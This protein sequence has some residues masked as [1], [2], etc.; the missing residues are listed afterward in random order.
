MD[1][2]HNTK[3]HN[4]ARCSIASLQSTFFSTFAPAPEA[5]AAATAG[6]EPA[7][8]SLSPDPAG[9]L[10]LA[11]L[12]VVTPA[13]GLASC[14]LA[15]PVA[16]RVRARLFTAEASAEA[17]RLVTTPAMKPTRMNRTAMSGRA[18][19][20][21]CRGIDKEV[22]QC[23]DTGEVHETRAREG[24]TNRNLVHSMEH[25]GYKRCSG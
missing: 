25:I 11:V 19:A 10:L 7:A 22:R 4:H 9:A 12:L 16:A 24:V 5:A 1:T 23:N 8:A 3:E 2:T 6:G 21:D 13:R 18:E 20:K 15:A 14:A 17:V